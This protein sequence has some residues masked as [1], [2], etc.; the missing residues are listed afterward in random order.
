VTQSIRAQWPDGT[1]NDITIRNTSSSNINGWKVEFDADFTVTDVWNAQ[2]VSH[3]GNHY[4][5][6]NIPNFWNSVIK[7][8][9][10]ITFGFNTHLDAGN[11]TAI[12]NI[13]LNGNAMS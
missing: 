5:F 10:E 13:L 11:S 8:N 4:V 1:T 6:Q 7:P 9:T 12:Q 2:L 3:T